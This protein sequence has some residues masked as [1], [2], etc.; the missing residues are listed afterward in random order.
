MSLNILFIGDVVGSPGRKIVSQA[1]PR[2]I[3]A[4]DLGLVVCNAENS[5]GGSGLTIK[6][7][8]ELAEAGV[9]VFTLGDHAYRKDEVFTL[10]DRNDRILRA[11]NY[12]LDAPGGESVVVPARDG[13]LVGVFTLMGRTFMKPVDD[14]FRAAD[15]VLAGLQDSAKVILVDIHAE[16]TSDKQL[17][18]R[19]LDGRVSAVLGTHTHVPTADEHIMPGGTAFQSDVGMTG[20]YDSILGRR[21]DRVL[22]ATLTGVPHFFDVASGDPRL[23][24]AVVTIDQDSGKALAIRRVVVNQEQTRRLMMG[25]LI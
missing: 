9:D 1:L 3:H 20:P 4:W 13:T 7:H 10:F 14:P 25:E 21:Y 8:E 6:C 2:L 23:C 19:Y 18:G 17:L 22:A 16:A 24:G 5:A 11:A 12:P 15:R